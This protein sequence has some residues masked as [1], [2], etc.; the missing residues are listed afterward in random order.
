MLFKATSDIAAHVE[1]NDNATF[2]LLVP[3]VQAATLEYIIPAISDEFYLE[4]EEKYTTGAE[5][6][7]KE[8]EVLKR[9]QSAL[10]NYM[11]CI[12]G[13][14]GMVRVGDAGIV[15]TNSANTTPTRQWVLRSWK[16]AHMKAGDKA[17][18]YA[19]K[20]LEDNKEFFT[21]WAES[22][23]YTESKEL[24]FRNAGQLAEYINVSNSRRTFMKL[25]PF[26]R[27]AERRVLRQ[28]LGDDLFQ[29]V[30]DN[31][32]AAAP[33]E[34]YTKLLQEYIRPAMAPIVLQMGISEM[35]LEV[36]EDGIRIKSTNDGLE[37]DQPAGSDD[38]SALFRSLDTNGEAEL[39][40]LKQ[41]L[42]KEI[43]TY[44]AFESSKVYMDRTSG[45][46]PWDSN[47]KTWVIV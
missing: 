36:S 42:M 11:L 19:L 33:G 39:E 35:N 7:P 38:K 23:A 34:Q 10:A 40:D 45:S 25:K 29:E 13:P 20:Y 14:K 26:I 22:E 8:Q 21:T 28:V 9:L 4:L 47:G 18:D 27:R 16:R 1:I 15:E 43:D 30:K 44:P 24:I 6:D 2:D 37:Q 3:S 12:Y 32:K 46:K 31:L 17:L 41:F 5:L